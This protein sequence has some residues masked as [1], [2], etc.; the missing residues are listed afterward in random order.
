M[1][2]RLRSSSKVFFVSS[3][4]S[5]AVTTDQIS[6]FLASKYFFATCNSGGVFG[7]GSGGESNLFISLASLAILIYLGFLILKEEKRDLNLALVLVLSGGVS[8][9]LDRVAYG[10]VR[11][12][13]QVFKWFPSFNLADVLIT[14][15]ITLFLYNM[16]FVR[17]KYDNRK[18]N[19]GI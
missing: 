9:F 15:G 3:F 14:A 10:C 19:P 1:R 16:L 2:K 8:N 11:D 17:T 18:Q 12:F 7:F 13:I 4:L 6:K 5:S